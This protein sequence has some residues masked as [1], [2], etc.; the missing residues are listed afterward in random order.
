MCLAKTHHREFPD[1]LVIRIQLFHH[2][3]PGS[4]PGLRTE[5]PHQADAHGSQKKKE[6]SITHHLF[7]IFHQSCDI[8]FPCQEGVPLHPLPTG[9]YLFEKYSLFV[10]VL[11]PHN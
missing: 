1:G 8:N 10:T 4:I 7:N 11:F 5:I 6:Y 9:S 2:C 3:E